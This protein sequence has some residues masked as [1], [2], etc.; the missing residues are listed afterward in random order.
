MDASFNSNFYLTSATVI[1]LFY[2][3]LFLQGN[4]VQDTAKW[5]GSRFAALTNFI[6]LTWA[7]RRKRM[8]RGAGWRAFLGAIFLVSL[9]L[10]L[11]MYLILLA[12]VIGVLSEGI[13]IWVLLHQSDNLLLRSTVLWSMLSL[14]AVMSAKPTVTVIRN[15]SWPS[16][17]NIIPRLRRLVQHQENG[18]SGSQAPAHPESSQPV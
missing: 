3:T 11:L 8:L 6:S 7:N 17:H 13:S 10:I 9:I 12:A 14:L 16:I 1:P 18:I 5:A 2:I 15:L 4:V